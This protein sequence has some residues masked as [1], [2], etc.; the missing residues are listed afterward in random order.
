MILSKSDNTYLKDGTSVS[1]KVKQPQAS[2]VFPL[3]TNNLDITQQA[4]E[5]FKRWKEEDSLPWDFQSLTDERV[6]LL[7]LIY[8]NRMLPKPPTQSHK[9]TQTRKAPREN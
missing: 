9:Q 2:Q 1:S 3:T 5:D 4:W 6:S 8:P 7:P